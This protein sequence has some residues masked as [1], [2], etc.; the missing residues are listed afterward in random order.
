MGAHSSSAKKKKNWGW[1][2][3]RRECLNGSIIIPAR[4]PL[5]RALSRPAQQW[6]SCIVLETDRPVW[7]TLPSLRS[8][9][10]S[11]AVREFVPQGKNAAHVCE[12]VMPD[13]GRPKRIKTIAAMWPQR[14]YLRIHC[15]RIWR[16]WWAFTQR[17]SKLSKLAE[18]RG[19]A[20][21]RVRALDWDNTVC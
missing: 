11:L 1:A 13:V 18:E 9:H 21:A 4:G 6:R 20:L 15:A 16:A 7:T 14:T 17:T 19:W 2:V 3:T 8:V 10:L 5:H 12:P